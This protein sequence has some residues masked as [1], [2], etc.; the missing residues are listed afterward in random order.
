MRKGVLNAYSPSLLEPGRM[1]VASMLKAKGYETAGMG[2]WHP[3]LGGEAKTNYA[4]PLTPAPL[5]AGFDS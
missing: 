2:K 3:G 4:K 1:T 5:Q